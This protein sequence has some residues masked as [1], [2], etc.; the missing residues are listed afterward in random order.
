MLLGEDEPAP[1]NKVLPFLK[2]AGGKR[3]LCEGYIDLFPEVDG[4]L[5]EP[6]LGSGAVFF[7]L[8]P[9]S[10]IL[11]DNNHD[12]INAY[13]QVKEN[14]KLVE[15][16]LV[17]HQELHSVKHYYSVRE[18]MP[19]SPLD[20]AIRFIYLN[21]TCWNGLY[22]V[23]KNGEFNVPIGTKCNV[24]LETD[25]FKGVSDILQCAELYHDDFE[26]V[27]DR[28]VCGDLIFADPP[29]TVTHNS[30]GFI[31]YN[32]KL[33]SWDDQLRLRNS[34]ARAHQRG[35]K[36]IVTNAFHEGILELYSELGR[37]MKLKRPSVISGKTS[38]RGHYDEVMIICQ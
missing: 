20:Q 36:A 33:F 18:S 17:A 24:T 11:S 12:L 2:W 8:V 32:A 23:N 28:A 29:Y 5:I 14:W 31:K 9:D 30:N 3:W 16:G 19:T 25:D 10:A 27:V 26:N 15:S 7:R 37:C 22:R 13:L 21:R 35:A 1:A 34:I 6:F 4:R 38:G